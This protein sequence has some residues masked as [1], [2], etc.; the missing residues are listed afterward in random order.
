MEKISVIIPCYNVETF[1]SKCLES[2]IKQTYQNLE[3]ICVDDGS[4]DLTLETLLNYQKSD[5][6][7]IVLHHDNKG[8]S[9]SRNRALTQ[10]S[11]KF[12]TFV[13]GDDWLDLDCI[14]KTIGGSFDLTCFSYRRVFNNKIQTRFLGLEGVYDAEILQ[15]RIIGLVGKELTDPT[16]NNSLVTV[17][18]KIYKTDIINN[19]SITFTST[20]EIGSG[21]DALFNIEYLQFC[22]GKTQVI[23]KPYYNYVRHNSS[24]ISSL[25]KSDLFNQWQALHGKIYNIIQGKSAIFQK[26]Y[27]S[28]VALSLIGLGLNEMQS[29]KSF[30]MKA[31]FISQILN[32]SEYDKSYKVLDYKYFPMHWKVLFLLARYKLATPVLAMFYIMNYLWKRKNN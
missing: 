22:K 9:F 3:I 28:R 19:N 21:E 15:Q 2:V 20:S 7:I 11:G 1:V 17:C 27:Y 13:D 5:K 18:A 8:V 12:V 16:N 6:R 4:S 32:H 24:S 30:A 26:A 23:D 10:C 31:K 14:E 25:Y 29:R